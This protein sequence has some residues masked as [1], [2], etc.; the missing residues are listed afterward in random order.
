MLKE[1][2]REQMRIPYPT[3]TAETMFLKNT[4]HLRIYS[5]VV[6]L[7]DDFT[8]VALTFR[9]WALYFFAAIASIVNQYYYFRT[10]RGG[11]PIYFINLT[12]YVLGVALAKILPRES[13]TIGGHSMSLNPG[14]FNIKEHALIGI[15]VSTAS[16]AYAIDIRMGAL[17]AIVL[18]IT[19]QCLGVCCINT[20]L[21]SALEL[22]PF[23]MKDAYGAEQNALAHASV[24]AKLSVGQ[25]NVSPNTPAPK[26]RKLPENDP[27]LRCSPGLVP[28]L[29]FLYS[30]SPYSTL[31]QSRQFIE[32]D[33]VIC[34]LLNRDW[35]FSP[36]LRFACSKILSG[37][38]LLN[39]NNGQAVILNTI[40]HEAIRRLSHFASN[41]PCQPYTIYTLAAYDQSHNGYGPAL[42]SLFHAVSSAVIRDGSDALLD[43]QT[44]E[45]S[46]NRC[47]KEGRAT[48]GLEGI[49]SLYTGTKTSIKILW[50]R[51]LNEYLETLAQ[52]LSTYIATANAAVVPFV[53]K[54]FTSPTQ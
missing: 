8:L 24:I 38:I 53:W 40:E 37:C 7:T 34:E 28:G 1:R 54:E 3:I 15:A 46:R 49:L 18:I 2:E 36:Q 29:E 47:T 16:T 35:E 26:K 17:D 20:G 30:I 12:S 6:L 39:N 41:H 32:L 14:P 42:S 48:Q 5:E 19:T 9:F 23:A 51:D 21:I 31:L 10:S 13:I 43:K 4:V 44:V 22:Q 52:I 25:V 45:K 50:N 11:F 33:D 27:C